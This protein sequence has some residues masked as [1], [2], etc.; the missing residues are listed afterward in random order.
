MDCIKDISIFHLIDSLLYN[1]AS[2]LLEPGETRGRL[3]NLGKQGLGVRGSRGEIPREL[4]A[5]GQMKEVDVQDRPTF[6]YVHCYCGCWFCGGN[7]MKINN[8]PT[9]APR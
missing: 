2:L 1:G 5:W 6:V 9:S 4:R 7:T 3:E 8:R